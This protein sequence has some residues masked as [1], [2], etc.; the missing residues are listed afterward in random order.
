MFWSN[1]K[2]NNYNNIQIHT[3][4]CEL[5]VFDAK[6][7][8][9]TL[10]K[11]DKAIIINTCSFIEQREKENQLL[12]NILYRTFNDY[13]FYI[14]GCDVKN[15]AN[16]YKNYTTYDNEQ[17]R[18]IL[19]DD[20]NT[21]LNNDYRY[22]DKD[23]I[24]LKIQDGCNHKCSFCIINKLRG[25]PYSL[26][27]QLIVKNLKN[28]IKNSK[29]III[30]LNGTEICNYYDETLNY[31]ITDVLE[32]LIKDF[33]EIEKIVISSLDPAS[34]EIEKIIN[35]ISNHRDKMVN[36]IHL[37][38]QSGS[39]SILK[40]MKRRHNVKR[41]KDIHYLALKNNITIGW[42]LIVGYPTET[43]EY[44]NETVSLIKELKPLMQ[45]IFIY[46]P[47]KNTESYL[48]KDLPENIKKER[49]NIIQNLVL[50]NIKN[51]DSKSYKE[52]I[53]NSKN[54][55]DNKKQLYENLINE[56]DEIWLDID[57]INQL[58][59]I[60]KNR[61]HSYIINIKY[62]VNKEFEIFFII[63]FLKEYMENVSIIL[64][65]NETFKE[66]IQEFETKCGCIIK[67][68]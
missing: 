63:N 67:R 54:I 66:N 44:F 32:N 12:L 8:A 1:Y 2:F 13:K 38:V 10:N 68:D 29:K 46:S 56:I 41:I 42:D 55:K 17:L 19:N 58:S 23:A 22:E 61:E 28:T 35:F 34:L 27:Y 25:K 30:E 50:E 7:F 65:I 49:F 47:R 15:N 36:H 62:N 4:G 18:N 26:P 39:D 48:L 16:V 51:C 5:S 33:P 21:C 53:N 6:K 20:L 24:F 37:S 43:E 3:T 59:N 52:Y 11:N 64:H 40:D 60:I 57:N 9:S 14:L 45:T 31:K